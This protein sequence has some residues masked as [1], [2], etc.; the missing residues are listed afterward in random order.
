VTASAN[1]DL[2]RSIYAAW[3]RGDY[4][5]V[6]W[7]DPEIEFVFA[8]GP[9]PGTWRG[10]VG[11]LEGFRGWLK[12]WEDYRVVADEFRELD[13]ERVFVLTHNSGRGKASGLEIGQMG[14]RGQA[15]LFHVRGGNVTKFVL[16]WDRDRAFADLGLTPESGS[17]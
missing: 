9:E 8:D 7:A 13:G 12:A 11:M 15:N 14:T 6:A 2:V 1:L 5:S 17:R 4:S 10:V 3:E 16:Y